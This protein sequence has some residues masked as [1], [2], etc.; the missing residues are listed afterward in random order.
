MPLTN[1]E[2]ELLKK[3]VQ[4][5]QEPDETEE[6]HLEKVRLFSGNKQVKCLSDGRQG[7]VET[8]E[9][10]GT[11]HVWFGETREIDGARICENIHFSNLELL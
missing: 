1:E 10:D 6:K 11:S 2:M 7:L 5:S 4:K 8:T 3:L 9:R